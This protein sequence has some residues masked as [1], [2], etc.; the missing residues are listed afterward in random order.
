MKHN[1][2][3]TSIIAF[4]ALYL[5]QW[6]IYPPFD[7]ESS[8]PIELDCIPAKWGIAG[9]PCVKPGPEP[10]LDGT[11]LSGYV[12]FSPLVRGDSPPKA[13]EAFQLAPIAS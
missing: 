10:G 4:V 2:R 9:D 8:G 13:T 5:R 7:K 11:R 1:G 6:D 3:E 12:V